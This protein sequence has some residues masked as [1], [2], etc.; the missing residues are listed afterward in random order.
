M[1]LATWINPIFAVV[2]WAALFILVKRKRIIELLPV[3]LLAAILLFAVEQF[4]FALGMFRFN[5][6]LIMIA[7]V[8]LFHLFWGAASGMIFINYIREEFSKK[9]PIILLFAVLTEMFVYIAMSVGNFSFLG[10]Y[11]FLFDF[12]LNLVVLLILAQL[13]EGLFGRRIHQR[14]YS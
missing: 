14:I 8:P 12:I 2:T 13:S 1:D 7:G 10:P 5:A 4:F 9:I 6:G 3:G 11:N